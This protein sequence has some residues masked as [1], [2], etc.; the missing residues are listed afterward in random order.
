M[1]TARSKI[2]DIVV[3]VAVIGLAIAFAYYKFGNQGNSIGAHKTLENLAKPIEG[4][5]ADG[6]DPSASAQ[7]AIG[8]GT[9][10]DTKK[11]GL[12]E[13]T[14]EMLHK[15]NYETGEV[16]D[17]LKKFD[18]KKV[19]IAG[20]IVPLSD[21]VDTLDN[22]L[23]VPNPQACIHV[24]PPPPN[25]IVNVELKKPVPMDS[26]S[27]PSWIE[28]TLMIQTTEHAY[29]KASFY[30]IADKIEEYLF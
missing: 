15:L 9:S 30:F 21:E 17:D 27:N 19:K 23:L 8:G 22:F 2:I 11:G 7:I 24:P 28:G 25:L 4:M 18:G 12:P 6:S 5:P 20:F 26:V 29:G 1:S 16:P 10:K 13:V 3:V 14:W